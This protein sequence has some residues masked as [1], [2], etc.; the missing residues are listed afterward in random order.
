M[1]LFSIRKRIKRS[2]KE[3]EKRSIE[4]TESFNSKLSQQQKANI[5]IEK[6][7]FDFCIDELKNIL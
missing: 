1:K 6:Q 2:I 5:F 4:L 3:L 7:K